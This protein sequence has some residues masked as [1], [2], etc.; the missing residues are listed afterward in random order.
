MPIK[1]SKVTIGILMSICFA[2]TA[3]AQVVDDRFTPRVYGSLAVTPAQISPEAARISG[4]T[5][6]RNV[7]VSPIS[8]TGNTHV[9]STSSP[10]GSYADAVQA[11]ARR[12]IAFQDASSVPFSSSTPSISETYTLEGA[13]YNVV[14]ERSNS[15]EIELFE[16]A[17]P[18]F[19]STGPL[20][21]PAQNVA[22]RT[23]TSAQSHYVIEG[24]TLYG[25]ARRYN[26]DVATLKANNGLSGNNI[27]IGQNLNIPST[28]RH[29]VASSVTSNNTIASSQ[30]RVI[31]T[32][33]PV[34]S[35][36]VYAVLPKDTLWSISQRACVTVEAIQAQN[37]LGGSTEI[38]PG[39]RLQMPAG[40]CLY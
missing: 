6:T 30:S 9:V 28:S 4:T 38:A 17:T 19:V 33:Q 7:V 11:E 36:G 22:T 39:Q 14:P 5:P 25:I 10:T 34:P 27:S 21:A 12:V 2:G 40:H 8:T 26:T 15:Y 29:I 13:Q 1:S 32:V 23:F 24:D 16:P 37:A 31:R 20:A 3:T 18:T 35:L